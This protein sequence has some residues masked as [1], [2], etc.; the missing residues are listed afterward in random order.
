MKDSVGGM[1]TEMR[2]YIQSIVF[3]LITKKSSR[4]LKKPKTLFYNCW[5]VFIYCILLQFS[6][7]KVGVKQNLAVNV[8]LNS[9]ASFAPEL[10]EVFVLEPGITIFLRKRSRKKL[11]PIFFTF[12]P[13]LI[14]NY[15]N[16]REPW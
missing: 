5:F 15:L 14:Y 7:T 16:F 3:G 8:G 4:V 1:E 10:G 6:A 11:S 12:S 13:E 2:R 9:T